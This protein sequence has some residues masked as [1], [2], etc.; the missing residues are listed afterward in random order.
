M[1]LTLLLTM[2]G[3]S[4]VLSRT[5]AAVFYR[6]VIMPR[7]IEP[8]SAAQIHSVYASKGTSNSRTPDTET[9]RYSR[10]SAYVREPVDSKRSPLRPELSN[11]KKRY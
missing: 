8:L 6:Q 3:S 11:K 7:N 1:S 5:F 4:L 10:T 9:A 2:Q